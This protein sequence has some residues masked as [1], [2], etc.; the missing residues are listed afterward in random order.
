MRI[1]SVLKI[2]KY[3]QIRATIANSW[4]RSASW[5][6][7]MVESNEGE[8]RR[9]F[10]F[11]LVQLGVEITIIL[12]NIYYISGSIFLSGSIVSYVYFT[13]D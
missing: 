8:E 6:E 5:N 10:N 3:V 11:F 7:D 4:G 13:I 1:F 12:Y 9:C 2:S